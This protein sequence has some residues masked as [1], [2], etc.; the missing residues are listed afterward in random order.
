MSFQAF[1]NEADKGLPSPV[2]LLYASDPFLNREAIGAIKKLVPEGEREFNL[3]IFDFL[4]EADEKTSFEQI[5]DVAN[6]APFF[7]T[8]RFVVFLGNLQRLSKKDLKRLD[9]YVCNPAPG[10][11]LLIFHEGAL[12]KEM[13]DRFRGL[14]TLSLDM[15]ETEIPSWIEHRVRLKGLE[16]SDD[17]ADYM[18]GLIGPDLGL[19]SAE[20]EKISLLGK[21]RVCVDDISGIIDGEGF[22]SPFDLVEALGE[23]NAEKVFRIYKAL[24]E[25]TKDYSLIGVLNW[26]YGRKKP[27]SLQAEK[28]AG[29]FEILNRADIDI[30]S[31]GRDFPMEYL[32]IKLLRL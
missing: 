6:T 9:A 17:V 18:L 10:S 27:L 1:L 7:G 2:Y 14:E 28:L 4:L 5:L 21:Q 15:R 22:Y 16:I 3:H 26:L 19:L 23:K 11:V 8:R 30:K 29:V 20:I 13:R 25:T 32:L 12:K 24:I 31:S